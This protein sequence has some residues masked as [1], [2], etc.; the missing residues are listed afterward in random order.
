MKTLPDGVKA[1]KKTLVFDETTVPR[2]LLKDHQTMPGVWGLITILEGSLTY[3]IQSEPPE[4][5][6]L[7]KNQFG[8]VEP[9]VL[10]YVK[11]SGRVKFYV[12]FY[13]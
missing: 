2:G 13:K 1:Y 4:V 6:L 9:Q 11:P 3:T 8:V 10:H 7:D 12:E 5:N